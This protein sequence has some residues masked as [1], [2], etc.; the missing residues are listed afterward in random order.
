MGLAQERWHEL[1]EQVKVDDGLP[2]WEQAGKWTEDKLFFWK[3]YIDITTKAMSHNQAFPNGLV[4]VDLF[5]GAGVCVL[6]VMNKRFPGSALIAASAPEPFSRIIAC[7]KKRELA[8]ACRIRLS[9][10]AVSE[11]CEVLTG[12]C[13]SLIHG[14][15]QK[16]P[17][18]TLTLAFIDP[19]GL[20]AKFSTIKTLAKQARADLVI[21]FADA[22]DIC[23]NEWQY[24][25]SNP[26]SKLDQ[27]LGPESQWRE[28]LKK[29]GYPKG[30]RK[31]SL[32]A[33]IYK[34]QLRRLLGYE[35]FGDRVMKSCG[36]PMY[37]LVYASRSKLGLKFWEEAVKEDSS[38]QKELF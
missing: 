26:N 22:Y 17:K 12:D 30:F 36:R 15:V 31:R 21:L 5:A 33:G 13:N 14:I 3:K 27:V 34:D 7:E 2:T 35:Y 32:F 6:K 19:K 9:N 28:I 4:Y 16:I 23:R 18:S 20:D 25:H 24:Y 11:R 37:R 38:G 8:E 10:S 29:A 1:L